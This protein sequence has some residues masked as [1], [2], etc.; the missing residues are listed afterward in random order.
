VFG[1]LLASTRYDFET[2]I[3]R[4]PLAELEFAPLDR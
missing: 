2:W 4:S 1:R 3:A